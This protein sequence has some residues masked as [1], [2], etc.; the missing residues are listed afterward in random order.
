MKKQS[1]LQGSL[2]LTISAVFAK[3][4]GA[5]FKLPLTALLGGTG[6]GY[7]SCAYGLFLP[8]YAVLVT[9][10][11]TA[12][13]K[14]V[15]DFIGKNKSACALK[16]RRTARFLCLFMGL[17]GMTGA[18]LSAK[19]FTIRTAGTMEAFPSVLAM[20]PAILFCCLTA[21]ERGYYEG[22]CS[23]TPT[24]VSQAVEAVIKLTAGLVFCHFF[25]NTDISFLNRYTPESRGA[26]G[27]VL[28]VTLSTGAGW[29]YLVIRNQF[30]KQDA[31]SHEIPPSSGR[32]IKL[33]FKIMIPAALGALVTNLTSLTDLFTMM[34]AFSK[35][36]AFSPEIFY[37]KAN[38][39]KEIPAEQASAFVYG[40]FMGLSVTVFNLVPSLTNMLAKSVLPCT[41]QAWSCGNHQ[42][43]SRY[44]RQVLILTGLIAIPAGCGIFALSD[45]ILAFL[46]AGR[47]AEIRTAVSGLRYLS[48]G[49][50]CLCLAFPIFSLLQAI[51]REDLPVKIMIPAIL[52]KVLCNLILIPHFCTAGASVSTSLCYFLIL[53]LSLICL[54][55]E[56]G[57]SIAIAKP[58][59]FQFWGG[60]LCAGTA[61]L[62]YDRLLFFFPQRIT[63]L[64]SVLSAVIVYLA[65]LL[66]TCRNDLKEFLTQNH[67]S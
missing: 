34:N 12:V 40:S 17:V 6:M 20:T 41:A 57:Q 24:A 2:L 48:F 8:I 50:I 14:P 33:L 18:L 38:L 32:I 15:A 11:S 59:F 63:F 47:T 46:F 66:L 25:L 55:K 30:R 35:M 7:F 28:G 37:Q 21:V 49:L 54:K 44:A 31:L 51:G 60:I 56:L 62:C 27:A 64:I 22:L 26:F 5:M 42:Q 45:G 58:L 67:L 23:M 53:M 52:V 16:I 19:A 9:G 3:L 4:C 1:F 10:L 61:W 39:S 43:A 13:A 65:V 36:L 29:L